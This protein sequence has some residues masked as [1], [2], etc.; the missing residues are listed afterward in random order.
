MMALYISFSLLGIALALGL[1]WC[2]RASAA[3]LWPM[4]WVAVLLC[5]ALGLYVH[6]GAFS[7]LSAKAALQARRQAFLHRVADTLTHPQQLIEQLKANI[8][9]HPND[10]QA[11]RLL[12]KLAFGTQNYPLAYKALQQAH[13]LDP[14]DKVTMQLLQRLEK[15]RSVEAA[16][17]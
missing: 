9:K 4:L 15:H 6:L 17:Q 7:R 16:A 5:V 13:R 12:G 10:L 2:W 1:L 3:K 14:K 11:W 8:A